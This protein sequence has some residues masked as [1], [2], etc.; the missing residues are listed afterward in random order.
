M[1]LGQYPWLAAFRAY[2]PKLLLGALGELSRI[3]HRVSLALH[4]IA[5]NVN[6]IGGI[7]RPLWSIDLLAVVLTVVRYLARDV[8]LAIRR[9][10]GHP[11]VA[12]AADIRHPCQPSMRWSGRQIGREWAAKSLLNRESLGVR[13]S[14]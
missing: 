9:R 8:T 14:R 1:P 7:G 4:T 5:A 10:F 2:C 6:D 11:Q 3:G 13:G 12:P